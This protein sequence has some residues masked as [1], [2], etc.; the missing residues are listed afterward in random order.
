MRFSRYSSKVISPQAK[1]LKITLNSIPFRSLHTTYSPNSQMESASSITY[2][3]KTAN[4]FN[5]RFSRCSNATR[6]KN[7]LSRGN[8]FLPSLVLFIFNILKHWI[9]KSLTK[10]LQLR[11]FY[12]ILNNNN[13]FPHNGFKELTLMHKET[14]KHSTLW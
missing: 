11:H 8:C 3:L 9:L 4:I 5:T 7:W 10:V 1:V 14:K 12:A 2:M 13:I 6:D